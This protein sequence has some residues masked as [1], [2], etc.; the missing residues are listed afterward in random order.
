MFAQSGK[1]SSISYKYSK[2][3]VS[4]EYQL[5][6][7]INIEN[8]GIGKLIY[9]NPSSTNEYDFT[10][11]R[12]SMK[13]LNNALRKSDVYNVNMDDMKSEVSMIGGPSRTMSITM[14][15]D[16][17]LD[18]KPTVIEVPGQLKQPYSEQIF[19]VYE[20]IENLVPNSIWN[21][22]SSQ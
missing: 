8:N 20:V 3:P 10:V 2:G 5:N 7:T 15:Q 19:N 16:P 18:A 1:W 9:T 12:K 17:S 4:P 13:R 11:G 21:K 14:W 6:Y 22:A